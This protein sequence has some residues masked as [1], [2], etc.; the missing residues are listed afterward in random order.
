MM[1]N[2]LKPAIGRVYKN[3]NTKTGKSF[4]VIRFTPEELE[5]QA[6]TIENLANFSIFI[7]QVESKFDNNFVGFA[8]LVQNKPK[9][10][11]TETTT[12]GRAPTRTASSATRAASNRTYTPSTATAVAQNK[13]FTSLLDD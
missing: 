7:N 6:G 1:T 11:T 10:T 9:E 5:A 3:K 4:L 13:R 12:A 2:K 8:T